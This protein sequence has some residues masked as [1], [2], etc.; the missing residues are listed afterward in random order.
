MRG[1][2]SSRTRSGVGVSL[3]ILYLKPDDTRSRRTIQPVAIEDM[4]FKGKAFEGLRAICSLRKG[5][6]T[7]RID[8]I[9]EVDYVIG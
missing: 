3:E 4:E 8:R 7:F 5:E 2:G 9:L 6:R 1:G